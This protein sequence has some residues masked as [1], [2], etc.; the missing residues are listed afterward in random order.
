[1]T[2]TNKSSVVA[3]RV[4]KIVEEKK[5]EWNLGDTFYGDRKLIPR[6]RTICVEPD[7]KSV[8]LRNAQRG[9]QN[10]FRTHV[11]IYHGSVKDVQENALD[12]DTLAEAVEAEINSYHNLQ[13]PTDPDPEETLVVHAFVSLVEP[14]YVNRNE[15][16]QWK[17]SRLTVDA[18]STT[19]LG[20]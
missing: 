17:V 13:D 7:T 2:A 14:R 10:N 12:C 15:G 9:V 6:N 16:T 11:L 19:R 1:M 3:Q 5:E 4:L 20:V 18:L 8:E